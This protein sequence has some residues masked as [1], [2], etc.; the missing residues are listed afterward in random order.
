M[1]VVL[2]L[3]ECSNKKTAGILHALTA[4]ADARSLS[5]ILVLYAGE[6][7]EH[8]VASGRY[9]RPEVAVNALVRAKLRLAW[10][11]MEGPP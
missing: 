2:R 3:V 10:D 7:G 8:F 5:D 11:Q 9:Q 4:L 6:D 1:G